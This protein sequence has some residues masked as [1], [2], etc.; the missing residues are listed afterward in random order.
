MEVKRRIFFVMLL[1]LLKMNVGLTDGIMGESALQKSEHCVQAARQA[2]AIL[3]G[4][5]ADAAATVN[6]I[7]HL[8]TLAEDGKYLKRS[9]E[10]YLSKLE[11][12]E[13]DLDRMLQRL[14]N[15][16]GGF[17]REMAAVMQ[18]KGNAE[19]DLSAKQAKLKDY[20]N[21]METSQN[22]VTNAENELHHAKR[23]LKKKK[24]GILGK[25]KSALGKLV[26][27]VGSAEKKVK[28]AKKTLAR[29]QSEFTAAQSAAN[30][31]KQ[32]FSK[33]EQNV[34]QHESRIQEVQQKVEAKHRE[35]R[36]VKSSIVLL[37]E[38]THFWELFTVAAENA[39]ERTA[40]L[41]RIVD[42]AAEVREYDILKEDGTVTKTKSFLEAWVVFTTLHH[43]E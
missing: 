40:S 1:V 26:G 30:T 9:A 33:V 20:Q 16:K 10:H 29:R 43:I 18:T 13:V 36:S 39:E 5:E 27:H 24:K 23:K 32:A 2:Y 19:R 42:I 41:Q 8:E 35:I 34:R 25:V 28:S 11:T 15:E 6:V 4:G 3:S 21:Q 7:N 17:E 12:Q 37:R 38:S 14:Q 22:E 31:A